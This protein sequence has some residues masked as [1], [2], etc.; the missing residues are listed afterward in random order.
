MRITVPMPVKTYRQSLKWTSEL[1]SNRRGVRRLF[2]KCRTDSNHHS[3]ELDREAQRRYRK[4]VGK[5]SKE[6]WKTFC[7]SINHLPTSARLHRT[8]SMDPMIRL[9]TLVTSFG[10][11]TLSEGENLDLLLATHFP[12]SVAIE[13]EAVPDATCRAKCLEWQVAARV[14]LGE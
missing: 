13:R 5:A 7:S 11:R 1:E 2:N 8:L 4:E 3:W 10:G 6:A 12:N 9:V 14:V